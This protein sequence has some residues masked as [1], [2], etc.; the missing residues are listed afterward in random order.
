MQVWRILHEEDLHPYHDHKVHLE[1]G[2]PTQRMD[3]CH[4]ITPRPQLLSVILFTD[5]ASFT[6]DCTNNSRKLHMWSHDNPHET[7]VTKSQRR[8]S[9]K[10]RGGAGKSLARPGMKQAT[11]I[12]LGIYLTS[13]PR[14]S[15]H[16]L[17]RC[18]N[19][20]KLLRKL[21]EVCPPNQFLAAAM[22]SASEEKWR[23]LNCFFSPGNRQ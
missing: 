1:P 2:D 5:E 21:S 6:R 13:Y 19:F 17:A 11:A 7:S 18:S 8:F 9:V 23:T 16:F 14:S 15:I 22:T 10:V 20:C 3:L 4:W 12:K